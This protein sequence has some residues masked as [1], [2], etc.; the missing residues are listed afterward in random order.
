MGVAVLVGGLGA[1]AASAAEAPYDPTAPPMMERPAHEDPEAEREAPEARE[2]WARPDE[3]APREEDAEAEEEPGGL[4][5]V[6]HKDGGMRAGQRTS[7]IDGRTHVEG[8][9]WAGAP[10]VH[11]RRYG[12]NLDTGEDTYRYVPVV[13]HGVE[14]TRRLP[15]EPPRVKGK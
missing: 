1:G 6:R 8:D 5:M 7:L 10:L 11:I 13:G 15:E 4:Q 9:E 2:P 3:P 14:K 12:V